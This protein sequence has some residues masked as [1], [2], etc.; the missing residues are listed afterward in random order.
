MGFEMGTH[1]YCRNERR[2]ELV[3]D[4]TYLNGINF[5]EV[6]QD[7]RTLQIHFIHPLPG[8]AGGFPSFLGPL[9]TENVLIEGGV[10]VR[11]VFA[12]GVQS[13]EKVLQVDVNKPGDFSTYKFRLIKSHADP[14]L[15][16]GFDPQLGEIEFSFKVGCPSEFDCKS[17]AADQPEQ[18]DEPQI[19]YL[20]KDYS[21][22]RRLMLDRLSVVM[23]KWKER[24][25]PDLEV[26]LVELLAY[27][28]DYLSYYQDAVASEAYLNTARKRYSI[29]RHVRLL[30]YSVDEGCNSR[31]WVCFEVDA[32]GPV[33]LSCG[34]K[35]LTRCIMEGAVIKPDPPDYWEKLVA[36][37]RCE[38]FELLHDTSLYPSHNQIL[39]YTWHDEICCLPKGATCAT[40][41]DGHD[42][43]KRLHLQAGD[44]LIFE[45]LLG[46]STGL[47]IDADP[48]RR[49][50]VRLTR[51][52]SA[53]DPLGNQPLLDIEWHPEDALPFPMY[54]SARIKGTVFTNMTCA[55]GNMALADHGRT[56]ENK[57]LLPSTVP[58][59]GCYRP[60]LQHKNITFSSTYDHNKAQRESASSTIFQKSYE[61]LP[62]IQ[63][64]GDGDRWYARHDL[65]GSERFSPEFVVEMDDDGTTF[66]RFGDDM[67]GRRPSP[68]SVLKATY[69]VGNGTGGNVGTDSVAHIVPLQSMK[70]DSVNL[71][72]IIKVRNPLPAQGGMNSELTSQV[73]LYAPYI[74]RRNLRGVTEEDYAQVSK[75]HPEV[76]NAISTLRWTGSWH[77]V[78]IAI[79]RKGGLPVD[80][81]F[82]GRLKAFLEQYRLA[83]HDIE[84]EAPIF[85]SLHIAFTVH[86]RPGY[87]QSDVKKALL[88][89][90]GNGYYPD[91]GRGFF[92]PDNF[93]FEQPVYL[94]QI[95]D[96][97]MEVA[98]VSWIDTGD[99][100]PHHFHRWGRPPMGELNLGAILLERL[101][102]ARLDNDPN[103]PENGK[104]EF[105]MEG[106]L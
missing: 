42:Q 86:V 35:L 58:L 75:R 37:N 14:I 89:A 48:S 52:H 2:K 59:E 50:A 26:A 25:A 19:D 70:R 88:K 64:N 76:T 15:L 29:R 85:V 49:H 44:V 94:S 62:V 53:V 67:C 95:V 16:E 10:R 13:K 63:L 100:E 38:V 77:T 33:V 11:D 99:R 47:G 6:S 72:Q 41:C 5:L 73:R 9:T 102:I 74:F 101:E 66:L 31:V 30:D 23:P 1:Y 39:F 71:G 103:A 87:L 106:G 65:L 97:A 4:Q 40:L 105:F 98:G 7:Q 93:S 17:S 45:E 61:A 68:G 91:I 55:R 32:G 78:F 90:F 80:D 82:K 24:H 8:Q 83:G 18:L 60:W 81:E 36:A 92:H 57:E 43:E 56:V 51:V 27:A 46:A 79:D 96:V 3:R 20:A 84:I 21:S 104:I 54:I 34:D 12:T 28:G 69:R 22:F